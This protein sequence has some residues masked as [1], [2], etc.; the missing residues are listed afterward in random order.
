MTRYSNI[1][2]IVQPPRRQS[3]VRYTD[4]PRIILGSPHM[5]PTNPLCQS[6]LGCWCYTDCPRI[7]LGFPHMLPTNPSV[8]VS[9]D[10]GVT[11]TVLG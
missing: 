7:I 8:R 3:T 10:V 11:L 6:I 4:C 1:V 2:S 5:L 9:L